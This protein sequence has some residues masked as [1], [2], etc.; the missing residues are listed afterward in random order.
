MAFARRP[1]EGNSGSAPL[2]RFNTRSLPDTGQGRKYQQKPRPAPPEQTSAESFYY[3]KQ[4]NAKT[5]MV[6]VM[7]DGE[8]IH[9]WIEW[10]DRGALKV[11][12]TAAPNLLIQ[13]HWIKY[14]Y[15]QDED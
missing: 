2:R 5:P 11:N 1:R 12:R 7:T 15:K 6:L 4:M 9:G 13:K 3:L 10:Y 14:L 8:V